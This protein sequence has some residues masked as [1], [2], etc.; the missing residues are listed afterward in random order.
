MTNQLFKLYRSVDPACG[1]KK[2]ANRWSGIDKSTTG[3]AAIEV[4][5]TAGHLIICFLVSVDI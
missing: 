2:H 3:Q 4:N 1:V 5:N